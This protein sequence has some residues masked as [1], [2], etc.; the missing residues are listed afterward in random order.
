MNIVDQRDATMTPTGV[1]FNSTEKK[2]KKLDLKVL[3]ESQKNLLKII[4]VAQDPK[5][6]DPSFF[7]SQKTS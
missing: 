1:T 5:K 3:T 4:K 6:L 2:V 7:E